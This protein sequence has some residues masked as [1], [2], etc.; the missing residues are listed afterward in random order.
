MNAP[1]HHVPV[2]F[3]LFALAAVA[4]FVYNLRPLLTVRSGKAD[5]NLSLNWGAQIRNGLLLGVGQRRVMNR[6]FGYATL[7]HFLLG[8]GFIELLFATTVDFLVVRGWFTAYLPEKDTPWFA[9][10]NDTGGLM[11]FA[12]LLMAL[13]RRH[14]SKPAVL[15]QNSLRGRGQLL[16]DSGI[17]LFLLL[18]VIGGFLSEAAR[19][20]VETPATAAYSYVGLSLSQLASSATWTA[21]QPAL[22]WSH[23]L[24]C[25]LFIALLPATKLFH[26]PAAI[27]NTALSNRQR[28]G[29]SPAMHVSELMDDPEADLDSLSLGA[30]KSSDFT[31]KQLL[32]TVSCTE[33]ARCTSVCPA[34][35]SGR[36]LSPMKLIGDIRGDLYQ[37]TLGRGEEAQLLGSRITDDELWSCTTCGACSGVCPVAID[38]VPTFTEMRRHL[39][40]SEGRPPEQASE[41]L[42]AMLDKGNPWGFPARDRT[43]WAIEAGAGT[44]PDEA[45]EAGRRAVLGWL[46]RGL[47]CAQPG[48]RARHG[49]PPGRPP[50]WIT[51]C[52]ATKNPA[53]AIRRDAWATSSCTNPW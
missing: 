14:L 40:M 5:P 13:Y 53:A 49:S 20:S 18:L 44:A 50:A 32:D 4:T 29:R 16:G 31:W 34:H 46:R 43:R 48:S 52:S 35:S 8:W 30:S 37:R 38:H 45:E 23:A 28:L 19:L 9:A 10:L 41:R 36:P 24:F 22:W 3:Y 17:L 11:L 39:V 26:V 7:M 12:G 6:R 25:L 42:E 51:L 47:R 15:P 1:E 21:W 2:L 27:L 33:C